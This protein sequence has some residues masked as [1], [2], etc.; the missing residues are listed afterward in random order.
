MENKNVIFD[1]ENSN[2]VNACGMSKENFDLTFKKIHEN[3]PDEAIHN[4]EMIENVLKTINELYSEGSLVT[5]KE[6][7]T[8]I[9][10]YKVGKMH[11]RERNPIKELLNLLKESRD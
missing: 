3:L 6:V 11:S 8:A 9:A 4:S 5:E 1:H 7:C 10:F 2:Y